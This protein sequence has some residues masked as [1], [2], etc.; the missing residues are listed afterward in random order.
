MIQTSLHSDEEVP[1]IN[2]HDTTWQGPDD[3]DKVVRV[4]PSYQP[5]SCVAYEHYH[6]EMAGPFRCEICYDGFNMRY[7][8]TYR[9]CVAVHVKSKYVLL[10]ASR[11]C[12]RIMTRKT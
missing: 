6:R 4:D 1:L 7:Y 8:A 9:T 5:G 10:S 2:D 3:G 11:S 12:C